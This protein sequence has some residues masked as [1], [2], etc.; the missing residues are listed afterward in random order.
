M[1]SGSTWTCGRNPPR[2][3]SRCPPGQCGCCTTS[4]YKLKRCSEWWSARWTE[5]ALQTL[6]LTSP[7]LTYVSANFH[8]EHILR[9]AATEGH[10][11]RGAVFH[12]SGSTALLW[13]PRT[14]AHF[15]TIDLAIPDADCAAP[16]GG[17][18][19]PLDTWAGVHGKRHLHPTIKCICQL[20]WKKY[21]NTFLKF[22]PCFEFT[23]YKAVMTTC[24][25]WNYSQD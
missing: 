7:G 8:S 16:V 24:L 6:F 12:L 14:D 4:C 1:P 18:G 9:F 13:A 22:F 10:R 3:E 11:L 25:S 19:Q 20:Y 17:K 5:A 2:E 21:Y 23:A 15:A